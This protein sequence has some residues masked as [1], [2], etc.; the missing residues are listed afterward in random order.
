MKPLKVF[1][2]IA[3]AFLLVTTT[4]ATAQTNPI[5]A[6]WT[7]V[8]QLEAQP[9]TFQRDTALVR[10]YANFALDM[11]KLE[12]ADSGI[13]YAEKAYALAKTISWMPGV[14]LALVRKASCQNIANQYFDA[15]QTGLQGLQLAEQ[16]Q[17]G[18]YQALFHR[19][20]GNNYDMLDNYDRAVPHYERCLKLTEGVPALQH[21]RGHA[22]VELG[23]AYRFYYKKPARAKALIEQAIRIYAAHDS[24]ALGYAYDYYGQALTDLKLYRQ[25]EQSFVRSEQYYRQFGKTYLLPE[26]LLHEAELYGAMNDYDRAIAKARECLL[27]SQQQK[28][29]YGLRGAYRILYEAG[30]ATGNYT[31]ALTN[32]EFYMQLNDSVNATNR[33]LKFQGLRADYELQRQKT[34]NQE[35]TIGKQKQAESIL[36]TGVGLLLIFSAYIIYNNRQLRQKNR[37]ILSALLQGQ[38]LERQRVAAD[39]HDNLGTTLSALHWNLETLDKTHLSPSE[40]AVYANISQQVSQAYNDVRLLAHNLLPEQLAKQGLVV[41]LQHLVDKLNRSTLVKFQLTGADALPRLGQ[42]TEFELYS[43]CLEL[44]QNTLKHANATESQLSFSLKKDSLCLTVSDNGRGLDGQGK[45]GRGL[46]NVAA[47]VKA[48]DG[49]WEVESNADTGVKHNISIPV[50]ATNRLG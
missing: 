43:I 50:N 14:L 13:I 6:T 30:K 32:H 49:Q 44:L 28:S 31:S 40:Q 36:L 42:Q 24:S 8:R 17:D 2:L 4:L 3:L 47:R 19:S 29:F 26:L 34:L 39:L 9:A 21:T 38:T 12:S 10:A 20:L 41:A 33:D 46:Q 37:A 5:Q 25:A 35:L 23:D 7:A 1:E 48:L 18:Y 45:D 27:V 22:L 16:Q 15:L 11:V